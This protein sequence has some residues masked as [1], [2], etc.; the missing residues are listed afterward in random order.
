M[1]VIQILRVSSHTYVLRTYTLCEFFEL[2]KN[3]IIYKRTR[4][5][6]ASH[7]TICYT[8]HHFFSDEKLRI[9]M[10]HFGCK[11]ISKLDVSTST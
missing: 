11:T 6:S 9:T 7:E 1:L 10:T 8:I 5:I 4:I 2:K 3:K